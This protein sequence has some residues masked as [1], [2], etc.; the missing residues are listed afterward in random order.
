MFG[1]AKSEPLRL[2]WESAVTQLESADP[3]ISHFIFT[4]WT[5]NHPRVADDRAMADELIAWLKQQSFMQ[6]YRQV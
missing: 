2:A 6:T 3:A 4:H 5:Q 1:G